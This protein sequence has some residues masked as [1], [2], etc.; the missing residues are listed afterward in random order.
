MEDGLIVVCI[1]S[2]YGLH[3]SGFEPWGGGGISYS[4]LPSTPALG[5]TQFHVQ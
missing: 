4:V 2:H 5:P 3:G 1:A